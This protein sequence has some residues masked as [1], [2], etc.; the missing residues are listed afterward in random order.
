MYADL[1]APCF[2]APEHPRLAY[3]TNNCG[4]LCVPA[5][6]ASALRFSSKQWFAAI[7]Y[8]KSIVSCLFPVRTEHHGT[9]SQ[10][11]LVMRVLSDTWI[12]TGPNVSMHCS[13]KLDCFL[14]ASLIRNTL[15]RPLAR[16]FFRGAGRGGRRFLSSFQR[17]SSGTPRPT[18]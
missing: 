3:D 16:F 4:S 2:S 7:A 12:T 13:R 18:S 11:L 6:A 8:E 9:A 10:L 1:A 5:F 17:R 14:V 15:V